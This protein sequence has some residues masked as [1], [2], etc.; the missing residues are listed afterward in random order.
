[1]LRYCHKPANNAQV[2]SDNFRQFMKKDLWGIIM[3]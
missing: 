1:M 3:A 2:D